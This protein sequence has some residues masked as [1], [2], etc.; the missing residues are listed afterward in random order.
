M[1]ALFSG[2][3]NIQ[4]QPTVQVVQEDCIALFSC[5][6]SGDSPQNISWYFQGQT[7]VRS[8]R[9]L[10]RPSGDLI[11]L[12]VTL[13]DAG[14]YQCQLVSGS[15]TG[16]VSNATLFVEEKPTINATGIL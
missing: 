10:V 12:N 13:S 3:P 2:T 14:V 15:G 9:I 16:T 6:D 5:L 4:V 8:S 7:I 11:I 1:I